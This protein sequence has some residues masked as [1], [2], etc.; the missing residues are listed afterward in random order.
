MKTYQYRSF[1]VYRFAIRGF[2]RG[3]KKWIPPARRVFFSRSLVRSAMLL[4]A[5]E[6][7][8]IG[9]G[10]ANALKW[11]EPPPTK[12]ELA[13]GAHRLDEHKGTAKRRRRTW[14]AVELGSEQG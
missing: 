6:L 8:V 1:G 7:A 4:G 5:R 2:D 3:F 11:W 10:G 9:C 12:N 13:C 14:L